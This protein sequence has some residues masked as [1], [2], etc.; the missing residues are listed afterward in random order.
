MPSTNKM[1]PASEPSAPWEKSEDIPAL[2]DGA[3]T[4]KPRHASTY[5]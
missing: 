4:S 5:Q 3:E 1:P 2:N